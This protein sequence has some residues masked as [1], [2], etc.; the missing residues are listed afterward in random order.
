MKMNKVKMPVDYVRQPATNQLNLCYRLIDVVDSDVERYR[1][2]G[3]IIEDI[4]AACNSISTKIA[5]LIDQSQN[6]PMTLAFLIDNQWLLRFAED[7]DVERLVRTPGFNTSKC[8]INFPVGAYV[9]DHQQK[10]FYQR[11]QFST[12]KQAKDQHEADL[13]VWLFTDKLNT[14]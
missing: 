9:T 3:E 6:D 7:K 2:Y 14:F 10:I 1:H 5:D 8:Y 12:W 4:F 11:R 13:I